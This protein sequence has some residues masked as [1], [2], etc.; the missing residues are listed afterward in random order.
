MGSSNLESS[1]KTQRLHVVIPEDHQIALKLTLPEDLPPGPAELTVDV[2]PGSEPRA[3]SMP[4]HSGFW[5]RAAELREATRGRKV[6]PSEELIREAADVYRSQYLAE[7]S[8]CDQP[9]LCERL[10]FSSASWATFFRCLPS[11]ID[12]PDGGA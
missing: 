12:I 2:E 8:A 5:R 3:E 7:R 6:T 4:R 10:S 9:A 11:T 1:M